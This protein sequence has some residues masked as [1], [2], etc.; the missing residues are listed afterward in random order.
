MKHKHTVWLVGIMRHSTI[1]SVISKGAHEKSNVSKRKKSKGDWADEIKLRT[2][3]PLRMTLTLTFHDCFKSTFS[4]CLTLKV[5]AITWWQS[6][7]PV[8]LRFIM[9]LG[10]SYLDLPNDLDLYN[11]LD[12]DFQWLFQV[13]IQP[14]M[15]TQS[16][17]CY[18]WQSQRLVCH[19]PCNDL[20]TFWPWPTKRPWPLKWP[21]P[22]F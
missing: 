11:D 12:L 18:L 14:M 5:V 13:Y 21:W 4:Q 15:Y 20:W 19:H 6:Q 2:T 1:Y 16:G 8:S 3:L 7:R 22:L 9:T 17:G 10:P